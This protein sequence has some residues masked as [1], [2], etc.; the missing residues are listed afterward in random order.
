VGIIE[1]KPNIE[2]PTI[3]EYKVIGENESKIKLVIDEVLDFKDYSINLSNKSKKGKYLSFNVSTVVQ[4]EQERNLI[5]QKF[6]TNQFIKM[7]I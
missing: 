5:F 7:V 4:T 6:K 1:E 3:W 2:Y